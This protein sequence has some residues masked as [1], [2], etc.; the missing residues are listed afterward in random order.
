MRGN[1]CMTPTWFDK[2]LEDFKTDPNNIRSI[3]HLVWI[4][5]LH[6]ALTVKWPTKNAKVP[7]HDSKK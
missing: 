3:L 4:N 1:K 5:A 6:S 2:A 7:R